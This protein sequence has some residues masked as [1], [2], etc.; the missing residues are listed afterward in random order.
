V[1]VECL[2]E[3]GVCVVRADVILPR[4]STHLI[5]EGLYI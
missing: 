3:R 2:L 1:R 4:A 5:L